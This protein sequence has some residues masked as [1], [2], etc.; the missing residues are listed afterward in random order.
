MLTLLLVAAS[1]LPARAQFEDADTIP[2]FS[3][4]ATAELV[5]RGTRGETTSGTRQKVSFGG[6]PPL[7][8]RAEY[9]L[10]RT[11]YGGLAASW[12]RLDERLETEQTRTSSTEGFT[13]LQFTGELLFKVKPSIPGYFILGGGARYVS[14]D[15]DDPDDYVHNVDSFTE[16][17]GILGAGVEIG[18]R[19]SR[20]FKLDFRLYF[21]SPAEQL[22]FDTKS[23]A[24]DFAFGV[25]FMLRL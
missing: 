3:I 10:T 13:Q 1:A 18:S 6:G 14:P 5:F 15:S 2:R 22:E 24:I 7:G 17:L 16:P 11:F 21:V 19:V 12:A 23:V 20:V 8:L 9:R 4:G 25:V